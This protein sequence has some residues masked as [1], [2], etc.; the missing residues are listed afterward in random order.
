MKW[1]IFFTLFFLPYSLEA[2][3]LSDLLTRTRIYL[4]DTAASSIRQRFSDT[5]LTLFLND[6]QKEANLRAFTVVS[7][8]RFSL[9]PGTTE[10]SLPDNNIV[11]LRVTL[12]H[13]PIPERTFSFLDDSNLSWVTDAAGTPKEYYVRTSSSLV[14]GVTRESIGFHPVSTGTLL[15]SID[16]LSQPSDLTSLLDVPFGVDNKRLYAYHHILAYRSAYL[17]WTAVG[18]FNMAGIYFREYEALI[19]ILE[20]TTKTRSSYNPNLRG[21]FP[22]P[23]QEAK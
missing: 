12:S 21:N 20:S 10:Y 22:A 8:T 23:A 19:P 7:S 2:L 5:Q 16:Y 1:A 15:A 6:S 18:D 11:V 4:R 14:A 9:T 13:N 3:T 17:G